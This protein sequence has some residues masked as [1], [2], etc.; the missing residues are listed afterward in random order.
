MSAGYFNLKKTKDGQFMFNLH[1]GNG[2]IIATS[3]CYTTEA[4]ARKGIASVRKHA[5]SA[6]VRYNSAREV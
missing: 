6:S 2:K 4:A 3:E 5:A 1:A